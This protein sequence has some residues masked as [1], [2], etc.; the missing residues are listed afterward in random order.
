[1]KCWRES[2]GV[3]SE[4]EDVERNA[5][6]CPDA[7][8]AELMTALI[9]SLRADGDSVGGVIECVIRGV[10]SRSWGTGLRQ[11]GSRSGQGNAQ[12]AGLERF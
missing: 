1:M 7:A 4:A 8:A 9:Q 10:P 2:I 11:T 5:V 12:S 6:R 3:P